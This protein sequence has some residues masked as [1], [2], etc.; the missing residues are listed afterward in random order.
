MNRTHLDFPWPFMVSHG[1]SNITMPRN[2]RGSYRAHA[3]AK[4]KRRNIR[5]RGGAK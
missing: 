1:T 3:R 4:A 5:L 2:R